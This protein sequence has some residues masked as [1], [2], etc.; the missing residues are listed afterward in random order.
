MPEASPYNIAKEL[1][2]AGKLKSLDELML[3]IKKTN[4]ANDAHI[5]PKRLNRLLSNPGLFTVEDTHK[6][7]A[8]IGVPAKPLLDL[9]SAEY[10]AKSKKKR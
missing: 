8:L 6:I 2:L 4:L 1:I 7:A 3:I 5:G 9:I 10:T